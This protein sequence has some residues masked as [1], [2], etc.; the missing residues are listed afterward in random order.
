VEWRRWGEL[1][2]RCCESLSHWV[3]L[4]FRLVGSCCKHWVMLWT[5]SQAR[6]CYKR[7][8]REGGRGRGMGRERCCRY[9][10]S[11]HPA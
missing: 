11:M 8:G 7:R 2:S 3:G 1:E 5:L 9:A 6:L 4:G 10:G